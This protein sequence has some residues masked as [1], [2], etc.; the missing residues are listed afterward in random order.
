MG[1]KQRDGI[2]KKNKLDD[3]DLRELI[4][5]DANIFI[6]HG[7][8]N[9]SYGKSCEWFLERVESKNAVAITTTCRVR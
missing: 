8:A 6:D 7:S 9:T 1:G 3:F 4:F 5:V 2:L